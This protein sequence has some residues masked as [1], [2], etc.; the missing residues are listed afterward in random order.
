[1]ILDIFG[2]IL[3]LVIRSFINRAHS[4]GIYM[5][6]IQILAAVLNSCQF[7]KSL[8]RVIKFRF[9][10]L[11]SIIIKPGDNPIKFYTL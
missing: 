8:V 4:I 5:P 3:S 11:I 6:G 9:F 7:S 10:Y 2:R 1:M